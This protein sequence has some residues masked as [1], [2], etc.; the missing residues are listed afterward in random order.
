VNKVKAVRSVQDA[1]EAICQEWELANRTRLNVAISGHGA[2]GN[3]EVGKDLIGNG[4][5]DSNQNPDLDKDGIPDFKVDDAP[6]NEADFINGVAKKIEHLTLLGCNVALFDKGQDF[7]ERLRIG[8][9]ADFVKGYTDKVFL[10]IDQD[11]H[12]YETAGDKKKAVPAATTLGIGAMTLL[13]LG[14][15]GVVI[16]RRLGVSAA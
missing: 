15:A 8:I 16:R 7:L 1:K 14:T 11:G 9:G 2:P 4:Q 13:V 12:R 6:A 5:V 3:Q 10:V